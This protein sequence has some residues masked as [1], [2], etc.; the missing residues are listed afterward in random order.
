VT[1]SAVLWVAAGLA[2]SFSAIAAPPRVVTQTGTPSA[3]AL[4]DRYERGD[5][6]AARA[7]SR[8]DAAGWT[9]FT[10]SLEAGGSVWIRQSPAPALDRRRLVAVS[11]ALEAASVV[12]DSP[13]RLLARRILG[14]ACTEIRPATPGDEVRTWYRASVVLLERA[15]DWDLLLGTGAGGE[16]KSGHLAHAREALTGDPRL[17]LAAV[18][19]EEGRTWGA[20]AVS[21]RALVRRN[22]KSAIG[23]DL[24]D[25]AGRFA[26]LTT[27][28]D[29]GPE[30]AF[31]LAMTNIRRGQIDLAALSAIEPGTRDPF[32]VY[33]CRLVT[34][35]ILEEQGSSDA[36]ARYRSALEAVPRAQS[37]TALLVS[38][39]VARGALEESRRLSEELFSGPPA[40][41]PWQQYRTGDGRFWPQHLAA[42]RTALR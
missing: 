40:P 5:Y 35:A 25:L 29:V 22:G 12:L 28:P 14:W 36:V 32:V 11:F 9:A 17:A 30:A 19:A 24:S 33:L 23:P 42:L 27:A 10:G 13:S 6:D 8:L 4:L 7:L 41:D 34:G 15:E 31:R 38:A 39:L 1:T 21:L 18:V 37:A 2:L 3:P 16:L 26:A 20:A